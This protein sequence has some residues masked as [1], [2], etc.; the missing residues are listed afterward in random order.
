MTNESYAEHLGVSVRTVANWRG[1][2]DVI[3]RP[4]IQEI[5]D[6]TLERAPD[7]VK[8]QFAGLIGETEGG[9]Q[10]SDHLE[11]LGASLNATSKSEIEGLELLESIN[12]HIHE[13]VALD[14]RFGGADLLRLSTRFFRNLRDRLGTGSYDPRLERDLHSAAGELAEVVGWLAYDA[15]AHDLCRR[16]NQESLYFTRLAG[17][18]TVELLTLQN[19]S[20]H[21]AAEGRPREAFQIARSV[22]EGDYRL[23]PRI[24]ALFLTRKAR[25]LAQSGDESALRLLPEIRDLYLS[26]VSD[27]DPA[28]AWWIDDRELAWHE[29]MVHRDLGFAG[30][31]I[32][33][34]ERSVMATPADEIR[35]QYL[36]RAYLLQSQVDNSTWDAA[37]RTAGQLIPLSREVASTRTTVILRSISGQLPKRA[38]VPSGFQDQFSMLCTAL[39]ES[40]YYNA[41]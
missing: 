38:E 14:N 21:A 26:G 34:F 11:S 9:T 1:N 36:H 37:E 16:M 13:I 12:S 5:L 25:A 22:L 7:R 2:P 30:E 39:D 29:A 27:S 3:P 18:K 35:S 19:S 32:G 40:P 4:A 10:E 6:V 17:D 8:A 31:A 33:H 24:K 28:W 41:N 23:S 20:M 15:E